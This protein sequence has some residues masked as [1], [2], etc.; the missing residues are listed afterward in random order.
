SRRHSLGRAPGVRASRLLPGPCTGDGRRKAG[1]CERRAFRDRAV[2]RS[3][4]DR[5]ITDA[6]P[7]KDSCRNADRHDQRGVRGR[8]EKVDRDREASALEAALYRSRLSA[9]ARS[10][11]ILPRQRLQD[12]HCDRRRP[13]F[14]ARLCRENLRHPAGARFGMLL[15]HDDAEREYAYGPAADLPDSKVG[16]FPP[17]LYDQAKKSKWTIISMKNDWKRIF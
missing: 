12:L 14:R 4:G 3:R 2:G 1:A 9:D 6:R 11:A 10:L 15:L 8:G 13:G 16:T 5:P 7:R 17:A